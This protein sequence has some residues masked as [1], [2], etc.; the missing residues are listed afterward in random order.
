GPPAGPAVVRGPA[1]VGTRAFPLT[2]RAP[3]RP[4]LSTA[5]RVNTTPRAAG[6][7]P[8]GGRV[9]RRRSAAV[10]ARPARPATPRRARRTVRPRAGPGS[11]AG[12]GPFGPSGGQLDAATQR[13][14]PAP[15]ATP[16]CGRV[17]GKSPETHRQRRPGPAG[18]GGRRRGPS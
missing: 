8:A 12:L 6:A 1:A 9:R 15:A 10:P 16:P 5:L 2:I 14:G 7:G 18:R 13:A 17:R 4:P 3:G 11:G